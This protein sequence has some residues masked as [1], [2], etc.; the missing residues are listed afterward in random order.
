[1]RRTFKMEVEL[2]APG[3]GQECCCVEVYERVRAGSR[4]RVMHFGY[5]AA[6]DEDDFE[7]LDDCLRQ[8]LRS[9]LYRTIGLQEKLL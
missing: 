4:N 9:L 5:P 1:M 8:E 2:Y 7:W 6:P 3:E